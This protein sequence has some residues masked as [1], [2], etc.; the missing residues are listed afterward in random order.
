MKIRTLYVRVV[1]TFLAIFIISLIVASFVSRLLYGNQIK[2]RVQEK[3]LTTGKQIITY[4]TENQVTDVQSFVDN[5]T[6][7]KEFKFI[8]YRDDQLVLPA[9]EI[10]KID[11]DNVIHGF[12]FYSNTKGSEDHIIIGLPFQVNGHDYALFIQIKPDIRNFFNDFYQIILTMLITV[13]LT[14]SLLILISSRY[15]VQPLKKFMEATHR[16]AEGDYTVQMDVKHQDE[17]GVLAGGFNHMVKELRQIEQMRQDFV[18]NVSHEIQSP[19]TSIRGFSMTLLKVDIPP[20][21]RNRYLTIIVTESER[22][23]RL[24]E[25]LLKLASLESEHHPYTPTS[26]R[27]DKQFRQVVIAAEPQWSLKQ[28][29]F[30]LS[31]QETVVTAD[32]DQMTQVWT[33]LIANSIK[34]TPDGGRVSIELLRQ[35]EDIIIRIT[36]SGIGIS[37]TE[38]DRIFQR[39]YKVDKA[40]DRTYGGSGL[41]LAIVQKIIALHHGHIH[42]QS[43]LNQGTIFTVTLKH[44][45]LQ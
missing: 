14:G 23:S 42:V 10:R 9:S 8:V 1:F 20:S 17:F 21:D 5:L 35:R 34:F 24:S 22:L 28:L 38:I 43:E 11:V 2:N 16:I 7:T 37:P 31:L 45:E 29:D 6:L 32:E 41:G 18:S 30:D 25:N 36:D 12:A 3:A 15:L 27:L 4:C 26:Y 13:L 33:N 39:F 40:R 44:H 19:L